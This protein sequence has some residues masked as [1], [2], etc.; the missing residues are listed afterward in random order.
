M[1][2][3]SHILLV[4]DEQ[5]L[6][7]LMLGSLNDNYDVT[8]VSDGSRALDL[9]QRRVFD[10]MVVDIGLPGIGGIEL[11]R[12]IRRDPEYIGVPIVFITGS[13]EIAVLEQ[14]Y[15]AGAVDYLLKPIFLRELELRVQTHLKLSRLER[16]QRHEL[17][18]RDLMLSMLAHDLRGTFG[19]AA[20]LMTRF[21][22]QAELPPE[23]SELA[24][25]AADAA[26]QGCDLLEDMLSWARAGTMPFQPAWLPL[27]GMAATCLATLRASAAHKGLEL[28]LSVASELEIYADATQLKSI[29]LNLLGNAVKFTRKGQIELRAART[30]N[31][32]ILRIE[33]SGT[34][35]PPEV[36]SNLVRG[37]R[38]L[39]RP[40]TDGERGTGMGL[41][42][43]QEF[44]RTHHGQLSFN[45]R[46]G[47]GTSVALIL[48]QPAARVAVVHSAAS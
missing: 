14:A 2:E 19:T 45:Q 4:E 36:L 10:L 26:Q 27:K 47:G 37:R 3:R 42:I 8:P 24:L 28:V 32:V 41:R 48:P 9:A 46:P 18:K 15:A 25:A 40:G 6:L 38:I 35:M 20:G 33:D 5:D 30:F 7:S 16:E 13:H 12:R 22:R 44:A 23:Q 29:L 21:G 39:S 31:Q 34:G 1:T 43:C 17:A 11:C